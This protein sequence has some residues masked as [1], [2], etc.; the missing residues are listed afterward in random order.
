MHAHLSHDVLKPV[1]RRGGSRLAD[2]LVKTMV[3]MYEQEFLAHL[4]TLPVGAREKVIQRIEKQAAGHDRSMKLLK[5]YLTP[6]QRKSLKKRGYFIVTAQSGTRY[7]LCNHAHANTYRL[8]GNSPIHRYCISLV[9]VP[10]GDSLLAQKLMLETNEKKF[11]R[12]A[13]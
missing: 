7:R 13:R 12:I 10:V 1:R 2:G 9:N 6:Y 5:R 3:L 11:L 8:R 4:F